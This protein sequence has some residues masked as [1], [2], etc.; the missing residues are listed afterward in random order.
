[1]KILKYLFFLLL[2]VIIAGAIYVA[3]KDGNYQ[4]EETAVIHAP[5]PVVFNEVN[6]FKNW[7]QWGPWMDDSDDIIINYSEKT[8]GENASYSWK[9]EEMGDGSIRNTKVI[10]DLAIEQQL[11]FKSPYGESQSDVYWDFVEVEEGTKVTWG[12]QGKQS[13]MDKLAFTFMDKSF[14]EMIRPMYQ[15]GLEKL[16]SV[17]LEKMSSYSVNVDGITTHG[18]GFYMYSTTATKIS[19]I[20]SKMQKMLADVSLYMEQNNIPSM[21]NPFV[22]YNNWDEQNNSAIYSTGY[23]TPSL[24]ITPTES[25]VLNGMMP[26]QKVVKTTLKGDYKNLKEA[27]DAAYKYTQE[28]NLPVNPNS[29]AFEVYSIGPDKSPNPANWVT[30][31]YIPLLEVEEP[32]L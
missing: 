25:T 1:M 20:P 32:T 21:G 2:I 30:E 17:V 29:P 12:I 8:I 24:I 7:D 9:S 27:W 3:T 11:I 16:N 13:F 23:F 19:Q 6:N 22:L 15:E 31:I 26:V 14:P 10:P 28:N 18:G 5:V 4:V